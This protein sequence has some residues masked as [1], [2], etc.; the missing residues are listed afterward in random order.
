MVTAFSDA[1]NRIRDLE[2]QLADR[3]TR[4]AY[5]AACKA[6]THWR[7]EAARLGRMAGVIPRE[8]KRK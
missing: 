6:L 1:H 4:D 7:K 8:M 5:D 2:A 3:P